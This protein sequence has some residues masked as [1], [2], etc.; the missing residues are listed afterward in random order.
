MKSRFPLPIRILVRVILVAG[1]FLFACDQG[2]GVKKVNLNQRRQIQTPTELDSLTYAC[3]PQYSHRVSFARHHLMVEYIAEK[4]GLSIRQVFPDSFKE[5]MEMVRDGKIDV[6][7]SNPLVYTRIA[8]RYQARA[9]A[10]I[11]EKNKSPTFRGQ[12]ICRADNK[13][14]ENLQDCKGKRWMAVDPA[15]AAGYLFALDHFIK[16]GITKS[17]F[18]NI[19]FAPGPGG[20]QETVVQAVYLGQADIGSIR[21]GT[22][23]LVKNRVDLTAIRILDQTRAF[24]SWVYAVRKDLESEVEDKIK[25]A[26]LELN[27]ENADHRKILQK[28]HF[29][30]VIPAQ[31]TDF[32]AI[33]RLLEKIGEKPYE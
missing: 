31:D 26:L 5:H 25:K 15:S 29:E 19:S 13:A 9:F 33:R 4:T 2:D 6:S 7:F 11:V 21:E 27:P 23:E 22:L 24:P 16:H 1:C 12:I 32:D 3:L 20:K 28:A 17:D 8:D 30:A 14:I 10:R 18:Q